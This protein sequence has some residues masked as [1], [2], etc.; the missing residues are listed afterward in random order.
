MIDFIDSLTGVAYPWQKYSQLVV[1]DFVTGAMENTSASV[2]HE[3]LNMDEKSLIDDPQDD[4]IIHELAHQWFGDYVTCSN[5]G[6]VAL[7]EGFATYF[8]YLWFE[9]TRGKDFADLNGYNEVLELSGG[10]QNHFPSHY[11]GNYR[12]ADD[13]MFD[14]HSYAKAS[15]VIHMLRKEVGDE[16]F[17]A[18]VNHYLHAN[19]N[20]SV[21][22]GDLKSAFEEVTGRDLSTFFD[23]WFLKK[24]HPKIKT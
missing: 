16:A 20:G 2:F 10:I 8:E 14:D 18:S 3:G 19:G 24:G 12:N 17:W 15:R 13:D 5:W 6:S 11:L 7:N 23:Q 9:H 21:L 22:I 1:H 4:I